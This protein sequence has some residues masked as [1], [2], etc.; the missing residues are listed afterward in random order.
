MAKIAL[1]T[2]AG[3]GIGK[4]EA[5]ELAKAGYDVCISYCGSEEQAKDTAE[6]VRA[7]GRRSMAIKADLTRLDD[8]DPMFDTLEREFGNIDVL[9]NN[10]GITKFMPFLEVSPEMFDTITNVDLRGTFFCAQRAAKDMIR[11]GTR[12]CI[13]NTSSVHR[14]T[15]YPKAS[16]YGPA[17]AAVYKLTQHM[18]LELA[19]YGIRV[20][21]V[22][23]GYIKVT[24]PNVVT[25]RE[26]MLVSRIPAQRT[27]Q[28]EEIAAAVLYLISDAAKYVT[29]SDITVDGG[30][31]L[32]SAVDNTYFK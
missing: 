21:S 3:H 15:N 14:G 2:G 1:V 9:V 27:G 20:N 18:A 5:I 4:G 32:P 24:D 19:P 29:G 11:H 12:G 25:D 10:A 13:I 8:I 26:K 28:P 23:P 17:K 22:S 16:V 31:L 30:Q 7:L 6:K